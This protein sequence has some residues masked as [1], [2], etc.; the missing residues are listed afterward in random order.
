VLRRSRVDETTLI[1]RCMLSSSFQRILAIETGGC[2]HAAI[3][4]DIS[5][6]MVNMD[7]RCMRDPPSFQL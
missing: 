1:S 3:R 2:P 4:E 5:A 6:N 7:L